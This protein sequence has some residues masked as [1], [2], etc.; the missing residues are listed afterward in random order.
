VSGSRS[1]RWICS[2]G[3][4]AIVGAEGGG[5]CVTGD[6]GGDWVSCRS[7]SLKS[8]LKMMLKPINTK[9]PGHQCPFEKIMMKI[10][11]QKN[12]G[13]KPPRKCLGLCLNFRC[14]CMSL[15]FYE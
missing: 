13:K 12:P 9:I 15:S 14:L 7:E 8:E 6:A 5:I 2:T 3:A 10:K 1:E 11:I 4:G